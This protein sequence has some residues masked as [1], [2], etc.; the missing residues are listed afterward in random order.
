MLRLAAHRAA[1]AL[2]SVVETVEVDEQEL[3]ALQPKLDVVAADGGVVEEDVAVWMPA[4]RC[5]GF[6]EQELGTGVG[7]AR[8]E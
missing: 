7:A 5:D 8:H 3:S 4:R 1:N 2:I 6:I